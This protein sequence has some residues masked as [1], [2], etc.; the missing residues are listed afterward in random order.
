[1]TCWHVTNV[2]WDGPNG[3]YHYFSHTY[4]IDLTMWLM[5]K[6][7]RIKLYQECAQWK[8][9][10]CWNL[11]GNKILQAKWEFFCSK[12]TFSYEWILEQFFSKNL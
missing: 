12:I 9:W 3:S 5:L 10:K 8:S 6:L 7:I 2:L 1:V 11:G 4:I